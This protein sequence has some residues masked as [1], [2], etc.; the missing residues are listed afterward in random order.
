LASSDAS[1]IALSWNSLTG[2]VAGGTNVA[3][4]GYQLYMNG[5]LH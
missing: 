4:T 5:S 1:T 3:I 2:T